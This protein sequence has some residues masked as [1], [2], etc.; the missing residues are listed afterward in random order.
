M[1]PCEVEDVYTTRG[2]LDAC[3]IVKSNDLVYGK[4]TGYV[5]N[6]LY[7][8]RMAFDVCARCQR[9]V[10]RDAV[11]CPRCSGA[12]SAHGIEPAAPTL[13]RVPVARATIAL[14]DSDGTLALTLY[15]KVAEAFL[16]LPVCFFF[17]AAYP[18]PSTDT[19]VAPDV[20][21]RR[22]CAWSRWATS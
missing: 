11:V 19:S 15:G 13:E 3:S 8:K 12:A 2:V 6:V 16:G 7:R 22:L 5:A 17:T 4:V 9:A 20:W 10:R 18:L 1:Q 14:M 21:W